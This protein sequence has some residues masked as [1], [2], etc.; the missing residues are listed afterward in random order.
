[1]GADITQLKQHQEKLL[2]GERRLMANLHDLHV[3]R[4]LDGERTEQ[5]EELNRKFMRETERAEAASQAKSQFLANMS[6]ELRTP[7]NAIIGF[8]EIMANA[9]FGPLGSDR[10]VEYASD[11]HTSGQ[12]LLN[13]INDILDMS[14]IEAGQ[15]SLEREEIDLCPLISETVRVIAVQAE[16]KVD[17]G[18]DQDPGHDEGGSPTGG[19]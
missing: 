5:L 19:R 17:R 9:H 15:V 11:I 7:L 16:A 18:R 14:K 2:E 10:Y 8:S 1:M 13:V 4:K 3:L 6:H 12:H